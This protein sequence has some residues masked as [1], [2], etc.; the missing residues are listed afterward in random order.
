MQT[1]E[2]YEAWMK[3]KKLKSWAIFGMFAAVCLALMIWLTPKPKTQPIC[4]AIEGTPG[5]TVRGDII[6]EGHLFDVII[7]GTGDGSAYWAAR[8]DTPQIRGHGD[9]WDSAVKDLLHKAESWGTG[10]TTSARLGKR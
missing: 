9:N 3:R 8:A 1:I 10:N 7:V 6:G 2:E 4:K 5:V